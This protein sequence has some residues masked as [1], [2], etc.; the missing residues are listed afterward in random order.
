MNN[1]K[2]KLKTYEDEGLGGMVLG[3]DVLKSA[4]DESGGLTRTGLGLADGVAT[5]ND[6]LDGA[7]LNGGGL[8]ETVRV[9]AAEEQFVEAEIIEGL[10][11][12][13]VLGVLIDGGRGL[14]GSV[15]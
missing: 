10:H 8:L 3:V 7:L 1:F 4:D 12:L 5:V 6:G 15:A 2:T 14:G 9:D 11:R 13:V